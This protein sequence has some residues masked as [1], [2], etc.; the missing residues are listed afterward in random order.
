[1]PRFA[2]ILVVALA[3]GPCDADETDGVLKPPEPAPPPHTAKAAKAP[4][5]PPPATKKEEEP[6]PDLAGLPPPPVGEKPAAGPLRFDPVQAGDGRLPT[7]PEAEIGED[8]TMLNH[9]MAFGWSARGDAF[10]YCFDNAGPG[11]CNELELDGKRRRLAGD[12]AKWRK[13]EKRAKPLHRGAERWPYGD[14]TITWKEL[15]AQLHVGGRVG[16]SGGTPDL[17]KF[18]FDRE[19]FSDALIYPE[20]ISVSPDG[21][22]MAIVAHAALGE[23]IEDVQPKLVKTSAFAASVYSA[24]GFDNLRAERYED[25]QKWFARATATGQHWKHPYNLACAR[26]RGGLDG[27]ETALRVAIDR[28][29]EAVKVKAR[30][31]TDLDKVRAQPWFAALVE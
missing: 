17:H 7:S 11:D 28:G 2:A 5:E 4:A 8:G 25:A 19:E 13:I 22:H 9:I 16:A 14:I 24:A 23:A 6:A 18:K 10:L 30:K 3:L 21:E 12:D 26:A 29:G 1:M 31:D 20:V 15:P 27:V